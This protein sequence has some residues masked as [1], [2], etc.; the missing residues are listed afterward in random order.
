MA[1]FILESIGQML[2]GFKPSLMAHIVEQKGAVKSVVWFARNMPRYQRILK[3][4]GPIR[5]HLISSVISTLNGCP[6][7]T[8]GHAYAFQLHFLQQRGELFPIDEN[9]MFAL[10]TLP[11][12]DIILRFESVLTEAGLSDEWVHV[13][14]SIAL[15]DDPSLAESSDDQD[16]VHL[17]FLFEFLNE[18][19]INGKVPADQAHDPINRLHDLRKRYAALRT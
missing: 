1:V 19:G 8:Y 18:C 12:D 13:R 3:K 6:Y 15:H 17:V 5:T 14:R 7:C 16:L 11:R 10:H 9:A 4:H 2:W